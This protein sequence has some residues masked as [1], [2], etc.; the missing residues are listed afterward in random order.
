MRKI[1][2]EIS[3]SG[4]PKDRIDESVKQSSFKEDDSINTNDVMELMKYGGLHNH[5]LF[6]GLKLKETYNDEGE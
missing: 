2:V 1:V 3:F 6:Y 4:N 5:S